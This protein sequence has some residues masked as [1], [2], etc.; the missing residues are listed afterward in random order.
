MSL[1][2][3]TLSSFI[4]PRFPVSGPGKAQKT[5]VD[6]AMQQ[7]RIAQQCL[8]FVLFAHLRQGRK[9]TG[10]VSPYQREGISCDVL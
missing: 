6:V 2:A 4:S 1:H 8:L 7:E 10:A 3:A 5:G 9:G